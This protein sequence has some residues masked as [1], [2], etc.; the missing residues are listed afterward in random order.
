MKKLAL[1]QSGMTSILFVFHSLAYAHD[2]NLQKLWETDGF[3]NPESVVYDRQA[4]VLYVSNVN[5]AASEKD[6]NGFISKVSL[7]GEILEKEWVTGMHAPKGLAIHNN[8][9][10]TADIDSLVEIDIA[11]ASITNRYQ[12]AD[13]KFLNDVAASPAGEIYVSDMALNRIHV[14]NNGEFS[15]WLESPELE[16]PNGLLVQGDSLILGAWGVMT[17]GFNTE[18]PGHLKSIS[19]KDKSITSIGNGTPIGN[20][21]GVEADRD[22]DYYV[23]DWMA[24]K[25][26]HIDHNGNAEVLLTLEQGMAD[27]AYIQGKDM[28]LLPMMMGNKLLAYKAH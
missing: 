3:S 14:F 5:G 12:V 11:T 23:T 16:A 25:L 7:N 20:L 28:I 4:D 8:K 9:L 10:Y 24:G 18:V 13:A 27:H 19:L 15:I 22:G 17:E 21:D 2:E 26:L 1:V 6:D